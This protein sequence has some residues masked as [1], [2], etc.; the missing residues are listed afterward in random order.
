[1][2]ALQLLGQ[3]FYKYG[4]IYRQVLAT[5]LIDVCG[6]MKYKDHPL[7]NQL[8]VSTEAH[9]PGLIHDCPYEVK[10]KIIKT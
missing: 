10:V 4:V 8:V 9:V 7:V 5:P 3:F 1:M 2:L 6:I